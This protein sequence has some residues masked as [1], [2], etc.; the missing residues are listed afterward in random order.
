MHR[1]VGAIFC[2][3][4]ASAYQKGDALG[5]QPQRGIRIPAKGNALG[6]QPQRG[7]RIPAQGAT[8]GIGHP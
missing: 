4:G 2:A 5:S 7:I 8:L 1:P 6:S 3:K